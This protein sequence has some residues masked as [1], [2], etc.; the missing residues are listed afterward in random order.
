MI[1]IL[2][3]V[4]HEGESHSVMSKFCDHMDYKSMEFSRPES[5]NE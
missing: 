2:T 3:G 5:W 1:A 4:S